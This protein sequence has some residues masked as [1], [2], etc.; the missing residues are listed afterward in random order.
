MVCGM[1]RFGRF[2]ENFQK[3]IEILIIVE[4]EWRWMDGWMDG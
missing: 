1:W 2:K 4:G 3:W